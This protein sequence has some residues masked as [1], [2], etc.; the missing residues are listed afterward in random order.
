L[1]A[2]SGDN[3]TDRA[4]RVGRLWREMPEMVGKCRDALAGRP[5]PRMRPIFGGGVSWGAF[6]FISKYFP[7]TETLSRFRPGGRLRN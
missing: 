3:H 1:V 2:V 6:V 7:I 5:G 4:N